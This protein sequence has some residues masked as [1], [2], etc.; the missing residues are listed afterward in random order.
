MIWHCQELCC[1]NKVTLTS[2]NFSNNYLSMSDTGGAAMS[3]GISLH[4][5]KMSANN[6]VTVIETTFSSSLQM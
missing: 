6:N 3:M 1:D 2:C 5:G 4:S